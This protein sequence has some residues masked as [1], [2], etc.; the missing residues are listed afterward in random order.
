MTRPSHAISGQ[1]VLLGISLAL[2]ALLVASAL[3]VRA[4]IASM[5]RVRRQSIA[6]TEGRWLPLLSRAVSIPSDEE[7]GLITTAI[8]Q[9]EGIDGLELEIFGDETIR[10]GS[11]DDR[12]DERVSWSIR[13]ARGREI[14]DIGVLTIAAHV[15]TFLDVAA[16]IV[17]RALPA[18][19]TKIVL[20][21]GPFVILVHFA[22]TRQ[23]K[24]LTTAV[25]EI[26]S[27]LDGTDIDDLEFRRRKL[28]P[29][30]DEFDQLVRAFNALL[31]GIRDERR[32]RMDREQALEQALTRSEYLLR[33][34]HHRVKNNLQ[35]LISMFS[36]HAERLGTT[37]KAVMREAE[38]RIQSLALVHVQLYQDES[39]TGVEL[40]SY[41][42]TLLNR[43][44]A[45]S[46]SDGYAN[47]LPMVDGDAVEL[48]LDKA[49][50]LALVLNEL[51][52]N[53]IKHAFAARPDGM[54]SI[55]VKRRA[56]LV[57]VTVCDDGRGLDESFS[58]ADSAGFGLTIAATLMDQI[59]AEMRFENRSA[60][61]ACFRLTIPLRP[62]Y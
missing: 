9:Q 60:G 30:D 31:G 36:L 21:L 12:R 56:D 16:D 41:A 61:G 23:L 53:A 55:V 62:S 51:V 52:T 8:A 33:E 1:F 54:I 46:H 58:L 15:P 45:S 26:S 17:P 3:S 42:R 49:I 18:D 28:F 47:I 22:V 48:P 40:V 7:I 34:V 35:M 27:R 6:R 2:V 59:D 25:G 29:R 44:I 14:L 10:I 38:H 11:H 32:I 13:H 50:P 37:E 39:I 5:E 57:I 24:R 4:E 20:I 19:L 43:L